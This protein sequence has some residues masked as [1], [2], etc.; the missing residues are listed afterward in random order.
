MKNLNIIT[1]VTLLSLF[2]FSACQKDEVASLSDAISAQRSIPAEGIHTI[3]EDAKTEAPLNLFEQEGDIESRAQY[4]RQ[5]SCGTGKFYSTNR[6]ATSTLNAHNSPCLDPN[7]DSFNGEDKFYIF[8]VDEQPNAIVTH[9]FTLGDM[10]DDL[11][12]FLYTLTNTY[13]IK[14]CK[15][16]SMT[17]GTDD[18]KI[19]VQGL[20]AGYYLLVVDGWIEQAISDYSLEVYCSAVSADPP[21][22]FIMD[23]ATVIS[24]GTIYSDNTSSDIGQIYR[25]TNTSVWKHHIWDIPHFDTFENDPIV[26][27]IARD[28]ATATS[29]LYNQAAGLYIQLDFYSSKLNYLGNNG[30]VL[31]SYDILS[32]E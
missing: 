17:I 29:Y 4:A 32:I 26:E 20:N 31:Q 14:D 13:R 7:G 10:T 5:I 23:D 24:F 22:S 1:I 6:G 30:E 8:R 12:L 28:E 21:S 25:P 16:T 9:H 15:A 19:E 3:N 18:E 11:D 2:V 27:E